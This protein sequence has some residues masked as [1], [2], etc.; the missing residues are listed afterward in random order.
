MR[1]IYLYTLLSFLIFSSSCT[2]P[3]QD[4]SAPEVI[5]PVSVV[6]PDTTIIKS[7]ISLN[8]VATYLLKNDIK[9][10]ING[11]ILRSNIHIG[12]NINR[13]QTLFVLETKEAKSIGN[14]I[15]S[16]DSSFKF[17]GINRIKSPVNSIVVAL[18]HQ[19]GDYVQEG[20]PLVTLAD[21]N[22]FG[23]VLNL[24]YEDH[25]LLLKNKNLTVLLPDSTLLQG[26]VAQIMPTVDSVSQ[27]QRVL[28]KIK[29]NVNIPENLIG[30]VKLQDK[31]STHFSLPKTAVFSDETQQQFWVMKLL[32]D[33]TAVKLDIQKGL[34]NNNRI[35][36]NAPPIL[37]TDRFVSQGGYGL[38]D[39]A[40]ILI[41][42]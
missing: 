19:T 36:I 16:L 20:E 5:T 7:D 33:S 38:G 1:K 28:I 41:Q 37:K 21:R 4:D 26:Y 42:K 29:N 2:S 31:A 24:P 34:E 3:T 18:S 23:F 12:D 17:S 6:M 9:A 22:S 30:L 10:N 32:N 35:E 39:T 15:N 25:Q 40:R 27:T 13:G 11:Y 14:T 8:A